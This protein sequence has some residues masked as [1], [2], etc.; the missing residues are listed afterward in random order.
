MINVLIQRNRDGFNEEAF[1]P[2]METLCS[3]LVVLVVLIKIKH[4][5]KFCK[6]LEKDSKTAP[7]V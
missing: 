4:T 5:N 7:C 6:L 2:Y 1:K 3:Q